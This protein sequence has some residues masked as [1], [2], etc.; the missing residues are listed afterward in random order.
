MTILGIYVLFVL[1]LIALGM[2]FGALWLTKRS[3]QAELRRE[4]AAADAGSH[5]RQA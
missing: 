3:Y 4:A 2:G 1:P 5:S